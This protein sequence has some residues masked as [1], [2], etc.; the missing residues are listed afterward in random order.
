MA[1]KPDE[2]LDPSEVALM[3]LAL[4]DLAGAAL[5]FARYGEDAGCNVADIEGLARLCWH[6][7]HRLADGAGQWEVHCVPADDPTPNR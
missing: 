3:A 1:D 7:A 5:A 4:A 6:L 2:A